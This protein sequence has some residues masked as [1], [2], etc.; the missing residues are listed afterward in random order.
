MHPGDG[1]HGSRLHLRLL[2]HVH[3]G[4]RAGF[5]AIRKSSGMWMSWSSVR[6]VFRGE[7]VWRARESMCDLVVVGATRG[8]KL[9]ESGRGRETSTGGSDGNFLHCWR[10]G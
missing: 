3:G 9:V 1:S 5:K 8:G 2:P 7:G 4:E 10:L 6:N